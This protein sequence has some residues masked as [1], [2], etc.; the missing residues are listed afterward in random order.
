[1][2]RFIVIT[3]V[4]FCVVPYLS[5]QTKESNTKLFNSA[6][7]LH[8][9]GDQGKAITLFRRVLDS[10]PDNEVVLYYLGSCYLDENVSIDSAT[11][12]YKKSAELLEDSKYNTDFGIDLFM[13]YAKAN[14]L[15]YNFD[16]A[17]KVYKEI[18]KFADPQLTNLQD[19]INHEIET[20]KNAIEMV[21]NPVKLEVKNLG[22]NVNSKYDDHSPLVNA[23]ESL[24]LFT[25][26]RL[27]SYAQIMDDGQFSE[28]IYSS[29]KVDGQWSPSE[30]IKSIVKSS[31]HEAGLCLSSDGTELYMVINSV[32]GRDIYV[33]NYDG[34]TWSEPFMLPEGINSRYDETHASINADKSLLFFTSNRK[35]SVGHGG[36]D[37]YMVRKLPNGKWGTPKNLGDVINTP[38]DEETPMIHANG[39]VLYFSSKGHN[40]MGGYDI[41]YS[42][43]NNDSTWSEPVNMGYPINTP[44]DDFFFVPAVAENRAYM[45]SSRFEDNYGGSDIYEIEYEAPIEQRLAVVKGQLSSDNPDATW[46]NVRIKVSEVGS[47][48]V[49]GVYKPNPITGKYILILESNKSYDVA[50]EGEE[51]ESKQET[52]KVTND[53]TY[54]NAQQSFKADNVNLIAKAEPQPSGN[55]VVDSQTSDVQTVGSH[56][57]GEMADG[58]Y[59]VQFVALNKEVK[60]H[61]DF[62]NLDKQN[63]FII[64]CKDGLYRYVYGSYK[65]FKDAKEA[66]QKVIDATGY[67]DPFVRY[68]W[69][70]DQLKAEE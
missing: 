53:M 12:F 66:K 28:K 42:V 11:Y 26:R 43:M 67:Q 40:T 5:G 29:S 16:E 3:L 46:D 45:A 48:E 13:S 2:S 68:L 31:S 33:S 35:D 6:I 17:I 64:K 25:S 30:I 39:K 63:I 59:T 23:D 19:E 9:K 24:L 60:D 7:D 51:I 44:D 15:S 20:S 36:L 32:K 62:S 47:D 54:H 34:E 1:M 4:M 10:E 41:F 70:L 50:Y 58:K 61:K 38:Y 57:I 65:T 14:Q 49:V 55:E 22:P 52:L 18:L 8:E 69:Q 37:I 27:S 56:S 21:K